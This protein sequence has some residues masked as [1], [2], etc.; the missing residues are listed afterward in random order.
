MSES[1]RSVDALKKAAKPINEELF[2]AECF[3]NSAYQ[4]GY[5]RFMPRRRRDA[6]RV[7][8]ADLDVVCVVLS[9]DGRLRQGRRTFT[10]APGDICRIPAG[11]PHDFS[12]VDEPLELLYTTIKVLVARHT[13]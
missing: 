4:T 3:A 8:H 2:F 10:V 13:P 6:K 1:V 5:V 9:G 11:T 12:A 7:V